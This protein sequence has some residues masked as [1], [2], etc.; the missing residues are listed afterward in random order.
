MNS[1]KIP[2]AENAYVDLRKL[3]DYALNAEHRVGQHKAR[4]F[5]ALLGINADDAEALRDILLQTVQ[6]HN[7]QI[8]IKDKHGQR[9]QLD[10]V[11]DW[12]DKKAI[13]RSA[14]NIRPNEKFPRLVT[15]YPLE[16]LF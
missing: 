12:Y 5:A 1:V 7:A 9:Y 3:R 4:L 16:E 13:V 15:C 14:W 8:G 6:T 2:N 10:F 11:L